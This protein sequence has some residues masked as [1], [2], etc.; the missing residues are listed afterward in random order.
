[1]DKQQ[2]I[3]TLREMQTLSAS[4][5]LTAHDVLL[6]FIGDEDITREYRRVKRNYA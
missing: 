2:A 6:V 4:D 5:S 3:D 1:M